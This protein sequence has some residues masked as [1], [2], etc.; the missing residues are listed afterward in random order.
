M[1]RN[2][3]LVTLVLIA[4]CLSTTVKISAQEDSTMFE[5]PLSISCDLM[6]RY[7][8]RGTDFGGSPSIQPGIEYSKNGFAI[9][10]WGAYTINAPGGQEVDMYASYT[11][12]D[13]FSVI[14]TDY[15]FPDEL[16]DYKYF[17]YNSSTTGH[18]LEASLSFN[19]TEKL[20]LS[21]LLAAN[22]WGDDAVRIND[23]G[24]EGALQYSTYAEASYAFK[25]FDLFVGVNLTGADTGRGETGFYGDNPGVVNL[26]LSTT[27]EIAISE[28]FSL[29]LSISLIT[30]P[31]A[32]K[33]YLV[34]GF[35]F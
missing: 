28:K 20:P 2:S 23:D 3:N 10:A 21:L 35:S 26:G 18:I 33:I 14:I 8:W 11:F 1:M 9:G 7:V 25:Y 24:S 16:A 5:S 19:G 4:V 31:Q 12:L 29:P 27:K 15:Y 22:F 34:A 17:S 13:M 6:S 32:E 30:N